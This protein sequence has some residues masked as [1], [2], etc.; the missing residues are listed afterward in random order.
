MLLILLIFVIFIACIFIKFTPS[1]REQNQIDHAL[2]RQEAN[3]RILEAKKRNRATVSPAQPSSSTARS[4]KKR[5]PNPRCVPIYNAIAHI[6]YTD[7]NGKTTHR[8]I[9][10]KTYNPGAETINAFC[11]LRNN[12][13]NF[14]IDRIIEAVDVNTGEIIIDMNAYLALHS[15]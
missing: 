12:S 2:A 3:I 10:I 7:I 4:E 13:R 5:R 9:K 14:R 1:R 15:Q 8:K 6:D 11:Y